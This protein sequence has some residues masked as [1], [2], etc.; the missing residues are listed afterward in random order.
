MPDYRTVLGDVRIPKTVL[1]SNTS[2]LGGR[3]LFLPIL[4]IVVGGLSIITAILF[5]I[6]KWKVKPSATAS[7]DRMR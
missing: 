2:W 4:Y 3:N 1:I 5:L 7:L 6:I